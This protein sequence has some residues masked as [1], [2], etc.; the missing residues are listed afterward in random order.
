M[1]KKNGLKVLIVGLDGADFEVMKPLL[2]NG[3]L[4]HIQRL[5]DSGS[6][7]KLRS[8]IPN[9]SAPAW[10]AFMTGKNPGQHGVYDFYTYDPRTY[11][12]LEPHIITSAPLVGQTF[13]DILGRLGY[14][15]GV[16][17]V[18]VTYPPWK[19]NGY[20][21]SGYPCPDTQQNYTFPPDLAEGMA[22]CCNFPADMKRTD[23]LNEISEDIYRM[24][25]VRTS[26]GLRLL[27]E[28]PSDLFCL[29][30]GAIDAAQHYFWGSPDGKSDEDGRPGAH[31]GDVISKMY[32][33]ADECLGRLLEAADEDTLVFVLS[34][35][36]GCAAATWEVNTNVWLRELGLL[37]L[38][39]GKQ[40]ASSLQRSAIQ[41]LKRSIRRWNRIRALLPRNIRHKVRQV[42]FNVS[43]IDWPATKAYRF[44]MSPPAEGLVINVAG[45]Q[46][47]GVVP[48]GKEYER[49]R[50][51]L[52]TQALQLQDEKT[53]RPLVKEIYRREELYSGEHLDKAPDIVIVFESGYMG[54]RDLDHPLITPHVTGRIKGQHSLD[55]IFIAHGHPFKRDF[56]LQGA[57]ILDFSPTLLFTLGVPIP[58]DMD[59][60]ILVNMFESSWIDR[61]QVEYTA[62]SGSAEEPQKEVSDQEKEMMKEKLRLLGYL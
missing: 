8:T 6:W 39:K 44:P 2:R 47:E 49:I 53:G 57:H 17:T 45:R 20:L 58:E 5:M 4:P 19:M 36:G 7:G 51:N 32:R 38:N 48:P 33:G 27:E 40:L 54:G 1:N 23:S 35:H 56:H 25:S 52:I 29:V 61:H 41:T 34:D 21:V 46:P 11:S 10:T 50:E 60:K 30:F 42:S 62:S 55:G 12:F 14:R 22:E 15:S 18:P 24:M 31:D 28:R 3:Q 26:L 37:K 43:A 9:M 13:W 59:G 16:I